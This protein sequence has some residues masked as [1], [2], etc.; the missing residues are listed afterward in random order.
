MSKNALSTRGRREVKKSG[1]QSG[2]SWS[3][4]GERVEREPITRSGAEPLAGSSKLHNPW[5]GSQRAKTSKAETVLTL[6]RPT[7]AANL[8]YSLYFANSVKHRYL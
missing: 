3:P 6:E 7:E 1:G 8:P 5:S 4:Q 2:M